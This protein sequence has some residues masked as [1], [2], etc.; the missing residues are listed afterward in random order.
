MKIEI[1]AAQD[2]L[3]YIARSAAVRP[4]LTVETTADGVRIQGNSETLE[5]LIASIDDS[6]DLGCCFADPTFVVFQADSDFPFAC[7]WLKEYKRER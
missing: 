4:A 6:L 5:K 2:L 3:G 7:D 1:K